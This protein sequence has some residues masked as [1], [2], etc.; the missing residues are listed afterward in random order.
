MQVCHECGAEFEPY[1]LINSERF[2]LRG[3]K[4]CLRCRAHRPQRRGR[5]KVERPPRSKLC[6][7]C[8][9]LFPAKV[10]IQ[11][12]MRSLYRRR[13]CLR[14]SPFGIHNTSKRPPGIVVPEELREHR[15]RRRNAKAYR[16]QKR[17]RQ[18]RK[19]QLIEERGGRCTGCG[20][21]ACVAA[22]EFHHRDPSTKKFGVGGFGG[23]LARLIAETEKCDLL[24][25]SCHRIRHANVE[26]GPRAQQ[27]TRIRRERKARAVAHMGG[28]CFA[29]RRD[30][31]YQL[32]EFHHLDASRKDFGISEDGVVRRWEK[33]VSELAKC[34]MLCA[35]CHREIHAGVRDLGERHR[36]LAETAGEYAA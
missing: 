16:S 12:K 7:S 19:I 15:R 8:G 11:G 36:D 28:R 32:F 31:P 14:C 24:C 30:G 17:R 9:E 23:S 3:R 34:V 29:C 13:F 18:R 22:L 26:R 4:R 25:A 10:L 1:P 6:E 21:S 33:V 35:N 2:N 20:Y 27:E 5:K